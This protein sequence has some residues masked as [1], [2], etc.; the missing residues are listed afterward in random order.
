AERFRVL[1]APGIAGQF[2][3]SGQ[4]SWKQVILLRSF[5][6]RTIWRETYSLV[7]WPVRSLSVPTVLLW[8]GDD[9]RI[10]ISFSA[11]ENARTLQAAIHTALCCSLFF[12]ER[13]RTAL[14]LCYVDLGFMQLRYAHRGVIH[15]FARDDFSV[16]EGLIGYRRFQ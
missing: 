12:R 10:G 14:L 16:L 1:T 3:S 4:A 11:V 13:N 9:Y 7:I 8:F 15:P 2:P 6:K 5:E